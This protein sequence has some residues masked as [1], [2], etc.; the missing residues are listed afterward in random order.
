MPVYNE[1]LFLKEA[2]ISVLSQTYQDFELIIIDD[3]STDRTPEIIQE[4]ALKDDRIRI[5]RNDKNLK[6][7]KS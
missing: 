3:C 4:Y 5:F 6:L 7:P 2:I 1:S